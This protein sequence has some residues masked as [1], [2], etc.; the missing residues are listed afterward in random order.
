M[1]STTNISTMPTH[2][3]PIPTSN[4]PAHA[5]PFPSLQKKK[6]KYSQPHRTIVTRRR[7]HVR[8]HGIPANAIHCLAVTLQHLDKLL[9]FPMPYIHARVCRCQ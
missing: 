4:S 3:N 1:K 9:L 8:I 6:K 2:S 5:N 7:K